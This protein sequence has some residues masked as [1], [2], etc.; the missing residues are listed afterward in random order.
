MKRH[1]NPLFTSFLFYHLFSLPLSLSSS[2][3]PSFS[4]P[5]YFH[6]MPPRGSKLGNIH[7]EFQY[8]P[9]RKILVCVVVAG[10]DLLPW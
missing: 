8:E 5:P 3:P 10:R 7:V 9:Q 4:P 1:L 2:L 6:T